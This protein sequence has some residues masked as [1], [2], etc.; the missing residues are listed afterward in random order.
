MTSQAVMKRYLTAV[1]KTEEYANNTTIQN[2]AI[3]IANFKKLEKK[4]QAELNV[5]IEGAYN[6]LQAKG[7]SV[8]KTPTKTTTTR[9]TRTTS[10][11]GLKAILAELKK[12]LGSEKFKEAT[13]GTDIQKDIKI[14]ALKKGKR[15]VR[16]KGYT[17]NQYGTFKNQVGTAYWESRANR[18]DANQ[19]SQTRKYKL[20]DGGDIS[21]YDNPK[22]ATH[23]LHIDGQNWYLEKIDSTHFYMSN[24]P[25]YRGMAHHIGQHKGESY[26]DEIKQWLRDTKFAKGG[27]VS[28][29]I[30]GLSKQEVLSETIVYDNGGESYDRYTIFT[31]DGSVYAMSETAEG[32]NQYIGDSSEVEKGKHLGKKLESVPKGIESAVLK[33]MLDDEQ[34]FA[35]SRQTKMSDRIPTYEIDLIYL[36]KSSSNADAYYNSSEDIR[37]YLEKLESQLSE[38]EFDKFEEM[39]YDFDRIF[40]ISISYSTFESKIFI[41]RDET[42][43]E[44]IVTFILEDIKPRYD[45]KFSIVTKPSSDININKLAKGGQLKSKAK[46]IPNRNIDEIEVTR[47]GKTTSI[48]GA[49]LLDGVY[50][51]KGT[52]FAKGGITEHGLKN[53][54]KI[55]SAKVVGTTIRVRN[56]SLDEDARV[57][58]NTGKRTLLTYDKK[59]KNWVEKMA[60]GGNTIK[61]TEA[62][63]EQAE[64]ELREAWEGKNIDD[65]VMYSD[66]YKK[67][68]EVG[69]MYVA[70][71]EKDGYW[72]IISKPSSKEKAQQLLDLPNSLPRGEVGKVVSV[73]DAKNHKLVVGREY[74]KYAKGGTT[75]RIKRRSC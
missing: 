16:K 52:K 26:Y 19:P 20:A 3:G 57:D 59:S 63:R 32:F 41:P 17:T 42:I 45:V 55:V 44:K 70:V 37:L 65:Y 14:P 33:R 22:N 13:T 71:G 75:K 12:K 29:Y 46:Y 4:Q 36:D 35:S 1:S 49:N 9:K 11:G 51:K 64:R 43:K 28:Q 8:K 50:V 6:K 47:N 38:K 66:K 56:E 27:E 10:Q 7:F 72:T 18:F 2:L 23:T 53:G 34:V 40:G 69:D 62:E 61:L 74:L 5:L 15:I 31:P 21:S 48:D 60:D 30:D 67:G 68:G 54:D 24:N 25:K 58:L 73:E 39:G